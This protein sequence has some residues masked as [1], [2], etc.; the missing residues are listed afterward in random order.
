MI[1]HGTH[2]SKPPVWGRSNLDTFCA[3]TKPPSQEHV[4]TQSAN[5]GHASLD[6]NPTQTM[7]SNERIGVCIY[8]NIY[9]YMYIFQTAKTCAFFLQRIIQ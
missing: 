1:K 9:I 5:T 3:E 8:I 6:E 4:E 2:P 7:G